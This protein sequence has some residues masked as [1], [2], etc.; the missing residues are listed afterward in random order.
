MST[1]EDKTVAI[2][3]AK[4]RWIVNIKINGK[5]LKQANLYRYLVNGSSAK[6]IFVKIIL[7]IITFDRKKLL[8]TSKN[9]NPKIKEHFIKSCIWSIMVYGS[10]TLTINSGIYKNWG[11]RNLMSMEITK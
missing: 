7:A 6:D 2:R 10:E 9:V 8:L 3:C 1:N 4:K 5:S 11:H